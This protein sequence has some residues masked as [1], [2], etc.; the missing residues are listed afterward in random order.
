MSA[1]RHD[2]AGASASA[3][4]RQLSTGPGPWRWIAGYCG[5]YLAAALLL[6]LVSGSWRIGA[7]AAALLLGALLLVTGQRARTDAQRWQQGARG[8]Q[9]TAR[10]L[11][12]LTRQGYT[13]LH[14]RALGGNSRANLDHLVIG[15]HGVAVLDS[16][17]WNKNMRVRQRGGYVW[18]GRT[19]GDKIAGSLQYEQRRVAS[20]LLAECGTDVV[21]TAA[22]V[23]HGPRLSAWRTWQISGIPML[24]GRAVRRW[25]RQLPA[26]YDPATADALAVICERRFPAYTTGPAA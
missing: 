12:P 13:V 15:P 4:A 18:A 9:A 1:R 2:G 21:V 7:G 24:Q 14:D 10:L 6:G 19:R 3:M 5:A 16:K 11:R 8:E 17:Q 25:I 26:H 20:A 23:I 22:L